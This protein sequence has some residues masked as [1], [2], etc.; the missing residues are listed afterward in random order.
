MHT[1][2]CKL[3]CAHLVCT[4]ELCTIGLMSSILCAH[5][6]LHACKIKY[7]SCQ[8][9]KFKLSC[10]VSIMYTH[11]AKCLICNP[12]E[13]IYM[14]ACIMQSHISSSKGIIQ[15]YDL[16]LE[17]QPNFHTRPSLFIAPANTIMLKCTCACTSLPARVC[18]H[19]THYV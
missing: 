13:T 12:Q 6:C 7:V 15:I 5:T 8:S 17:S 10:A 2:I 9:V 14:L 16:V 4:R 11:I 18:K 3:S 19:V 1:C